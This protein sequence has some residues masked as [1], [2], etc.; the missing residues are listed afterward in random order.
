MITISF[1]FND[2]AIALVLLSFLSCLTC[3]RQLWTYQLLLDRL[4]IGGGFNCRS[5]G[6]GYLGIMQPIIR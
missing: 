2:I 5:F 3:L 6:L 4:S 1:I